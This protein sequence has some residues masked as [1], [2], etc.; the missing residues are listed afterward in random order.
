VLKLN[1]LFFVFFS[2]YSFSQEVLKILGQAE[3]YANQLQYEQA[4]YYYSIAS[5]KDSTNK[6]KIDAK[7]FHIDSILLHLNTEGIDMNAIKNGDAALA[8]SAHLIAL[9]FYSGAPSLAF[10]YVRFRVNQIVKD[11]PALKIK[12]MVL[13]SKQRVKFEKPD[14]VPNYSAR[15]DTITNWAPRL[16]WSISDSIQYTEALTTLIDKKDWIGGQHLVVTTIL[17]F[18]HRLKLDEDLAL[19]LR[20]RQTNNGLGENSVELLLERIEKIEESK[21][22]NYT[23]II[24]LL[25]KLESFSITD[26]DLNKKYEELINIYKK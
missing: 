4:R 14:S 9:Q 8:D 6:Y 5:K 17:Q 3:K 7:I 11:R 26:V 21:P 19:L 25:D 22:V 18:G 13:R 23:A 12:W 2:S 1:L 10:N 20:L 24:E 15:W 16:N